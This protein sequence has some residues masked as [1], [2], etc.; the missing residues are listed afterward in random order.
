MSISTLALTIGLCLA[1]VARAERV[2]WG[3]YIEPPGARP[4]PVTHAAPE[5]V[6]KPEP[7]AQPAKPRVAD[8]AKRS[9]PA[10]GK[11]RK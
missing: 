7:R 2:D 5:K 3:Q 1:T 8:K 6:A 9:A 10:R 4:L 11:R